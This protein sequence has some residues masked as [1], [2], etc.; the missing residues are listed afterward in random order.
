MPH[1]QQES[2]QASEKIFVVIKKVAIWVA[3][4]ILLATAIWWIWTPSFSPPPP[5]VGASGVSSASVASA[6][7]AKPTQKKE[8]MAPVGEYSEWVSI[9]PNSWFRIKYSGDVKRKDM[10]GREFDVGPKMEPRWLGDDDQG[11]FAFRFKSRQS[12]PVMV[13]VYHHPK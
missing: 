8:V 9:P 10:R 1:A 4:A 3:G 7:V 11:S 13:A 12:E 5:P 2:I 6:A